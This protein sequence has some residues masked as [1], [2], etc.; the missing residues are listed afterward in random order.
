MTPRRRPSSPYA[1]FLI[2]ALITIPALIVIAALI[3]LLGHEAPGADLFIGSSLDPAALLVVGSGLAGAGLAV[4]WLRRTGPV[5][6][7]SE[8]TRGSSRRR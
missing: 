3:V 2:S 7:A 4:R 6:P 8:G 5:R 1:P